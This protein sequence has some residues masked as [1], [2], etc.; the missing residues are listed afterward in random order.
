M[1]DFRGEKKKTRDLSYYQYYIQLQLEYIVVELR[2]KIY[3]SIKDKNYYQRVMEGKKKVIEDISLR[4][5]LKSIFNSET[6]KNLRYQEIYREGFP[7]FLYRDQQERENLEYKDKSFYYMKGSEVR[8]VGRE[9][10]GILQYTSFKTS[11][12]S[13]LFNESN[14]ELVPIELIIRIL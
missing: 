11:T 12:A 6:E 9:G 2:R 8:V 14:E 5:S 7:L 13:V 10:V 1:N 4:N 3:P